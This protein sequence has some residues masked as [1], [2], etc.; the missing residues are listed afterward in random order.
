[1]KP[2]GRDEVIFRRVG[3][4]FAILDAA[5]NVL[6]ILNPTAAAVW[7][8][9]DGGHSEPEIAAQLCAAFSSAEPEA[10]R[11]DVAAAV[12]SFREKGLLL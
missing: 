12:R 8:L 9:C 1:M 7:V 11:S 3:D 4:E 10:V 6:H 2:R 5:Q